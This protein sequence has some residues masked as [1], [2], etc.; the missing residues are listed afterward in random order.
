MAL[1]SPRHSIACF[2]CLPAETFGE[3]PNGSAWSITTQAMPDLDETHLVVGRVVQ[4]RISCVLY[5]F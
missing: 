4:V 3:I 5:R 1:F 2:L